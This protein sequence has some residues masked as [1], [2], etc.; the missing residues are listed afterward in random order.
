MK[1]EQLRKSIL[2]LAIQ[3]KLVPQDPN[4]E[5]ASVLLER[6][7][8]EKQRLIKEGKIKKDKNDSVIFK[9]DDNRYYEKVGS[10]VKD[11][12]DYLPFEI[13]DN[14]VWARIDNY[15]SAVFSGK[16]P[17]YSKEETQHRVIGQ[18]ANQWEGVDWK[19]VK[20]CTEEFA[21]DMP[22]FYYLRN[23]DVLLNTLG[24][25]TLGRSGIFY[26][27]RKQEKVLTDGHLFVFRNICVVLS[28]Y[29]LLYF[30]TKYDEIVKSANGSTNQTFLCLGRTLQWLLPVP[31]FNE[32]KRIIYELDK[33]EPLID[34]YDKLEQQATKLDDEI[35]DKL[36][37]SIL[38]YAIQGK[39]VPQDP[40]D[41]PASVLL[42]RIRAEKKAKLG[43]KYV[44][45]YIYKGDD[46]CYYEKVGINEPNRLEDLPFDIP[47]SW[48]WARL[49]NTVI[50]NPRNDLSDN[51]EVS[52][53]EMKAIS[54]GYNNQFTATTRHWKAVKSGFTHFQD[55]D[56]GFAKITPC[57]Q[58]R[59]SVVFSSLQN[60][61]GAG[62]TEL[63]ILRPILGTVLS[64]YLLCF[65]KSPYLIEHGK[66]KFSGT[67]GQQRF[68]TDEVKKTLFP[69]PPLAEQERIV[70]Q[71]KMI[72]A[73]LKGE[74]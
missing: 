53:V 14:W 34:E 45:S 50:I 54:D 44:D 3:G 18:Q 9:G 51:I 24:N 60:A 37:K 8:A 32:I 26:N 13:P 2:Q 16:S 66:R 21:S 57:F 42:E 38:Q 64:K 15:C 55:N 23:G 47:D 68:G 11:I 5:P 22:E 71:V 28:K 1:A 62:T 74:D 63:H 72:L 19:Y 12:T 70:K 46:N 20:Y 69:L 40:N 33:F 52:F 10:E 65:V 6:I 58:N 25:G 49:E 29:L 41:E 48:C 17:K 35:Y 30:R 56:V 61:Y 31:P 27:I 73:K 43:K 59:K 7:H 39:L 67:A 4:D 36:K